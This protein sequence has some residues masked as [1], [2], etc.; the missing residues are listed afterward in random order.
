MLKTFT[1]NITPVLKGVE[2][3]DKHSTSLNHHSSF[4]LTVKAEKQ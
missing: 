1:S 4:K 2:D 3:E